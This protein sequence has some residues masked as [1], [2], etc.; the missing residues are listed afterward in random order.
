MA[1]LDS[2]VQGVNVEMNR[3]DDAS[4][5]GATSGNAGDVTVLNV[6]FS[7]STNAPSCEIIDQ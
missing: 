2:P 7:V 5:A 1:R 6:H 4:S 3:R